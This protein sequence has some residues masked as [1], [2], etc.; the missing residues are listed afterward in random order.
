MVEYAR[1]YGVLDWVPTECVSVVVDADPLPFLESALEADT[2]FYML[3]TELAGESDDVNPVLAEL[4]ANYSTNM[5]F[6][7]YLAINYWSN[8]RRGCRKISEFD[9]SSVKKDVIVVAAGPSLDDNLGFLRENAGEKTIIAVGTVFKK[10]LAQ[11]IYPDMVVIS[12][13]QERTYRQIEGVEKQKIPMLLAMTAYWRFAA[14]YEGEKYLIPSKNIAELDNI[15]EKYED[16]WPM[17]G[18]VTYLALEAAVRF[19][20]KR[21][22]LVGVD[23]A[24]PG[25]VTHATDTMDRAQK[26]MDGLIPI[27]G[28]RGTTVYS[29]T[30]FISYRH[31][32]EDMIAHTPWITYYNMSNIGAKIAGIHNTVGAPCDEP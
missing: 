5:I 11:E 4:Y 32:I 28:T 18:T 22:F 14:N 13:P 19:K 6:K 2:G 24:Y 15:A 30:V 3:V 16:A 20:A 25:G 31:E 1:R 8:L 26:S 7:R 9:V 23:L 12:D 29:D 10:L 27:E 21:I 17:G